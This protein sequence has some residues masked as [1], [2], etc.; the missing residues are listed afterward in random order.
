MA[1]IQVFIEE[2]DCDVGH[3]FQDFSLFPV[4]PVFVHSVCSHRGN[5][6]VHT[7]T[8]ACTKGSYNAHSLKSENFHS[9]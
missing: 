1:N 5:L 6:H 9:S 2:P 8:H 4:L 3:I 7:H